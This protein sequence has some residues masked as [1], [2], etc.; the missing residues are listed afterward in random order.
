MCDCL[1]VVAV[2][3]LAYPEKTNLKKRQVW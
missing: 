3:G 1:C 2:R